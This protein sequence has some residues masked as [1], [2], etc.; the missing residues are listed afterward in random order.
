MPVKPPM[1]VNVIVEL[2]VVPAVIER[3]VGFADSVKPGVGGPV[4]VTVTEVE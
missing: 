4:T 2:L 1:L 3:L